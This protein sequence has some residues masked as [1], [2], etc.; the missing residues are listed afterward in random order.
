MEAAA[1]AGLTAGVELLNASG[2]ADEAL[3]AAVK[4]S[5][6][7]DTVVELGRKIPGGKKIVD[8]VEDRLDTQMFKAGMDMYD[9][10]LTQAQEKEWIKLNE[11]LYGYTDEEIGRLAKL[12]EE[13]QSNLTITPWGDIIGETFGDDPRM[14]KTELEY[15]PSSGVKLQATPGKTTT[16]LGTYRADTKYILTELGNVKSTDLS[17]RSG[18][19]NL[20]NTPD[21]LYVQLGPERFWEMCNQPWLDNAIARNDVIVL[22]TK[23]KPEY[24][25][26]IDSSSGKRVLTGF[27]KEYQY[28]LDHGY[29]Y[30]ETTHKMVKEGGS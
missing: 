25:A 8:A 22:A 20:L 30:E 9:Q 17:G 14:F 2:M 10:D 19:F 28:L 26:Y 1:R 12:V 15:L 16:V 6:L 29:Q 11:H 24:C 21:E 18:G 7:L 27:G 3:G 23:P 4:K 13:G 5:G